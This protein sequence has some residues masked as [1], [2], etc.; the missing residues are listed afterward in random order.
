MLLGVLPLNITDG[1]ETTC[2]LLEMPLTELTNDGVF[3]VLVD[4]TLVDVSTNDEG[5]SLILATVLINIVDVSSM[6]DAELLNVDDD[7]AISSL[8]ETTLVKEADG[9]EIC[10][11][12]D[13]SE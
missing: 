8:V 11:L 6:L 10:S 12:L 7:T 13:V 2:S 9:T 5:I 1:V 3:G 4:G